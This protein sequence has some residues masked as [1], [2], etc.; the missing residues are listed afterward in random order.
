MSSATR[1]QVRFLKEV[2]DDSTQHLLG[3]SPDEYR[4]ILKQ[5]L[6]RQKVA[7]YVDTKAKSRAD[8]VKAFIAKQKNKSNALNEAVADFKKRDIA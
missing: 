7:Y 3:I 4:H 2:Y 5:S 8:E 6:L 1:C